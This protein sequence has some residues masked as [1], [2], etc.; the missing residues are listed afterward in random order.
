MYHSEHIENLYKGFCATETLWKDHLNGLKQL[1]VIMKSE[2]LFSKV[3][4]KKRRL[5]QLA[6]QFVFNQLEHLEQ[7]EVLAENIQIQKDKQTIGELDALITLESKPIHLEIVYKFYVYD[8]TLGASEIERWIGP[9][10]KDSLIEKIA[11]LKNKQL[12]LL[13]SPECTTVLKDLNLNVNTIQQRVLFKAQL[14]IPYQKSVN[15]SQLNEECVC[16]FYINQEELNHFENSKFYIPKKLDWFLEVNDSVD[17]QSFVTFKTEV[18]EFLN[19][20]QSPLIWIKQPDD[21]L[22]KCFLVWW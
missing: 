11:K 4:L 21:S 2:S 1:D 22:L 12:P 5:G 20:S 13:Y 9:N 18:D 3:L 8:E 15:F 19:Q 14:F 7:C 10:R 6:E 17:W 16:G